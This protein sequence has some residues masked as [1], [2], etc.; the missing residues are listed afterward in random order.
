MV[1]MKIAGGC[2]E[3]GRSC[4]LVD[5][6]C[7]GAAFLVDCGLSPDGGFPR[8]CDGEIS[9]VGAVFLTDSVPE[10]AG[11]L[12]WLE[13][14]GFDGQVIA[15]ACTLQ[16]LPHRPAHPV[17]LERLCGGR[18]SGSLGRLSF[19]Y[20]RSGRS[21][22]SVWYRFSLEGK[23]L[24]FSGG[25]TEDSFLYACDP[26][27]DT[28]AD[29]A[30]L[31]CA[32]GYRTV[33]F[34]AD[35]EALIDAVRELRKQH[36]ML[37]LPA[38]PAGRGAELLYLLHTAFPAW[39][40]A[41]DRRFAEQLRR[42][43]AHSDRFRRTVRL[44]ARATGL[45]DPPAGRAGRRADA[46]FVS[47]AS[48]TLPE[49]RDIADTVLQGGG[50]AVLTDTPAPGTRAAALLAEGRAVLLPLPTHSDMV[51]CGR[52]SR[53]NRFERVIPAMTQDISSELEFVV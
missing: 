12:P 17:P 29:A 34:E 31:D 53:L 4:C 39:R 23:S 14:H 32:C 52:L 42:M 19:T 51:H 15:S 26:I 8:L 50:V 20:G 44:P 3:N 47:D 48:L 6:D 30:V 21:T 35:C 38:P 27:R 37:L 25:Y 22:G 18:R 33:S 28:R 2:G 45:Y 13:S 5:T 36:G 10:R 9:R 49:D 16:Q 40:F 1:K 46:V 41:F 7:R 43:P 24:L 11:A